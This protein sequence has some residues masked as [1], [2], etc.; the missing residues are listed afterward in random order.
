MHRTDAPGNLAGLFTEGDP[1]GSPA[2]GGTVVDS[3]WLNDVQE[4]LA[5]AIEGSG[6]VLEKGNF[7]QLFDAIQRIAL[8]S[9][10]SGRTM[11]AQARVAQT[12][13]D[14]TGLP[15]PTALGTQSNGSNSEGP[16]VQAD[17]AT[18]SSTPE[19]IGWKWTFAEVQRSWVPDLQFS[20]STVN[21]THSRIWAGLFSA[22]PSALQ[23][24][25]SIT[26]AAF[27]FD[28]SL[29]DT[30]SGGDGTIKSICSSATGSSIK[31]TGI[32]YVPG[33]RYIGRIRR[34][35]D[36]GTRFEFYINGVQVSSHQGALEFVPGTSTPIGPAV[37]MRHLSDTNAKQLRLGWLVLRSK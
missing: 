37:L 9:S 19:D 26:S 11:R 7:G 17:T 36:L 10:F 8:D 34:S 29:D 24:P 6:L 14:L 13:F 1:Y 28:G 35:I 27:R 32:V 12:T 21:S 16:Y 20:F 33:T 25:A 2:T 31:S 23:D 30:G 3:A 4:N 15:S 22:D 5:K 18:P